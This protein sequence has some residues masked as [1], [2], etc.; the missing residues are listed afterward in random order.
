[1]PRPCSRNAPGCRARPQYPVAGS[2]SRLDLLTLSLTWLARGK[3]AVFWL[4]LGALLL[5]AAGGVVTRFFNQPIN[6]EVMSWTIDTLPANWADLRAAWWKWH[7]VRTGL[8]VAALA[9]L[10][11]AIIAA[12]GLAGV[13]PDQR[14]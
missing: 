3:G 10:L 7:L 5:M 13:L 4:Y 1:M 8:S 6:A 2:G 11:A 9:L 12:N 14:S